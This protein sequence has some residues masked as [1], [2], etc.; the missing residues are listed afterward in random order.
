MAVVARDAR[1]SREEQPDG[2]FSFAVR[3]RT[4]RRRKGRSS[5]ETRGQGWQ[6]VSVDLL[7][8]TLGRS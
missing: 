1:V 8:S 4:G 3:L 7:S 2:F 5:G 6:A